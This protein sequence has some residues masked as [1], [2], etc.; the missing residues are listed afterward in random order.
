MNKTTIVLIVLIAEVV[1]TFI[2]SFTGAS[3]S[4]GFEEAFDNPGKEFKVSGTL[5]QTKPVIYDPQMNT[6]LTTFHLIDHDGV[7][8]EVKLKKSKPTGLEQSEELHL[9]GQ[10]ENGAFYANE[11]LMKCPSKYDENNHLLETAEASN[12]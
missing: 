11:M 2:A 1:E 9:Y 6:Q 4:V 10:V 7:V 5:D 3:T 8:Q 12:R